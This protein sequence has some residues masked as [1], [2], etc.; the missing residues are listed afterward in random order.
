MCVVCVDLGSNTESWHPPHPRTHIVIGL[1]LST[2]HN[3][4]TQERR[5]AA[6]GLAL[7]TFGL[8]YCIGPILGGFLAERV[9]YRCVCVCA[10]GGLASPTLP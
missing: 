3:R 7:A 1:F 8:S 4:C 6:Y 10:C 5:S 2:A 9:S